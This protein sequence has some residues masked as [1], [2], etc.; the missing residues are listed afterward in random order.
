MPPFSRM[1]VKSLAQFSEW[2]PFPTLMNLFLNFFCASWLHFFNMSLIISSLLYWTNLGSNIAKNSS[3]IS[4][5]KNHPSMT[6]KIYRTL[7][8]KQGRTHKWRS[9][10]DPPHIADLPRLI[11]F[12]ADTGCNFEDLLGAMDDRERERERESQRNP[13]WQRDLMMMSLFFL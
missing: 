9:S 10:I 12:C 1:K 8:E 4:H 11:Q 5:L 13:C 7:L 3:C 6:N 2:I